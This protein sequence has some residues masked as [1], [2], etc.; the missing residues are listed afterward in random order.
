MKP[1]RNITAVALIAAAFIL[2]GLV[3]ARADFELG[4]AIYQ[5]GEPAQSNTSYG[6]FLYPNSSNAPI[7]YDEVYS[8]QS[9]A[10]NG[11][12]T[13]ASFNA[14]PLYTFSDLL[15]ELTNGPW[16]ITINA[17][18]PSQKVYKFN[19]G[20][21]GFTSNSIFPYVNILNPT[22]NAAY[23]PT[24]VTFAFTGPT[25]NIWNLALEVDQNGNR[26]EST[27]LLPTATNWTPNQGLALNSSYKFEA[28]Y[29]QGIAQYLNIP[30]PETTNG[31]VLSNWS[32]SP[33]IQM[34]AS[35]QFFTIPSVDYIALNVALEDTNEAWGTYGDNFWIGETN[36]TED[37]MYAAQSG[38]MTDD[39]MSVLQTT[40]TGPGTLTFNWNSYG[41]A[42]NFYFEFDVDGQSYDFLNADEE[43]WFTDNWTLTN[44]THVLTWTAYSGDGSS[45]NDFGYVGNV[46]YTVTPPPPPS[47]GQWTVTGAMSNATYLQSATLLPSGKVLVAGGSDNDSNPTAA[48]ELYNPGTGAWQATGPMAH[49][50]F[51]HTA[52]L[53]TNGYVLVAGGVSNYSGPGLVT[54]VELYN[55]TNATW[56]ATGPL[57][58]PRYGHTAT[59]L[60]DG[61]VLVAGGLGTNGSSANFVEILPSET[62]NPNTGLWKTNGAMHAGRMS[63]HTATLL[64]NGQVLVAG[65]AITNNI[66]VTGECELFD[67]ASS[68]WTVSTPMN[69]TLAFHT[70][71]RLPSG[72]V[73][74]AGGDTDIG[75]FGGFSYYPLTD[76]EIYDPNLQ[77]WTMTGS[78]NN[79][80][81]NHAAVLLTNGLVLVAGTAV[82][83]YTTNSA[84]LYD[85]SVGRWTTAA[86]MNHPRNQLTLTLLPSG[87]ALA[88]G[89][90]VAAAELYNSI[91]TPIITIS[92]PVRLGSGA[93]QFNWTNLPGSSNDVL[94]STNAAISLT[95]WTVLG[96]ASEISSG[97]FQF[98]DTQATNSARRFYR[99][100]SP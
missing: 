29:S 72:L 94:Y 9:N 93:F 92:N 86:Q 23:V 28:N 12:G 43:S 65:G 97:Y 79:V 14:N 2:A 18:D 83:V 50:R 6:I 95:N 3:N 32:A 73:L 8:S 7:T 68:N 48:A 63:G 19:I 61:E 44:G 52:T 37:G 88:V 57:H 69:D 89:G 16:T 46:T 67:P 74:V 5:F 84:E 34:A 96:G 62:Y 60:A 59:L 91:I 33:A 98:T 80:H 13:G 64:Q 30:T 17:G 4:I 36:V 56:T 25:S 76:A 22:N 49:P 15:N 58:F 77:S 53:L 21:N 51:S 82:E 24:N 47:P 42:D 39:E 90:L 35:S 78:L 26:V 20:L 27:D 41:Q 70:A 100:R 11:I 1:A 10:Y 66:L 40:V 81:D 54:N 87:Q 71:T 99:V 45:T 55:P 85:P 38:P 75:S 31:E